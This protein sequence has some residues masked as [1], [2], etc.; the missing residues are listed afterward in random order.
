MGT[1]LLLQLE[2]VKKEKVMQAVMVAFGISLQ[3]LFR[4][5]H[6]MVNILLIPVK[7]V[8]G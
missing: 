6:W 4:L 1:S 7:N 2:Q 8:V 5:P 3:G